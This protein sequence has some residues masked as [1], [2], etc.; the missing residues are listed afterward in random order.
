M[1]TVA[2]IPLNTF[3]IGFGLAGLAEAWSTAS[4]SL[5]IPVVVAQAFWLLVASVWMSLIVAH[6]VRGA[7]SE[8]SSAEQLRHP[9]QGPIAALVPVTGMLIAG[10]VASF[11][12]AAGVTIFLLALATSAVFA[13]WMVAVWLRGGLQLD[14]VHG[15]WLLPTVA[16]GL[17]GADVAAE[18][19]LPLLGWALFGVGA[20]FWSIMT[21]LVMARLAFGDPLPDP[22]VPTTAIL[23]AP[24]GVAG[25]AW[26]ALDGLHPSA[27]AA[28][29][30]GLAALLTLTQVALIPRYRRLR[31]SLGFWSFTF[32]V[33]AVTVE[34]MLWLRVLAFPGWQ[35]LT[36]ALLIALN[37]LIGA[38][39]I[40]TLADVVMHRRERAPEAVLVRA[41]DAVLEEDLRA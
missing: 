21:L 32:P 35:A 33:A 15:G 13:G 19:G 3:A 29:I 31:F 14:S 20:F 30:A 5:G 41:D 40:R 39:G 8:V 12:A 4:E 2:R 22:L 26:F 34:A 38:I 1:N 6:L 37:A 16:A 10:N 9:V 27:G 23:L 7:A 28:A 11:S 36:V 17:V 18:V 24:P 25:V